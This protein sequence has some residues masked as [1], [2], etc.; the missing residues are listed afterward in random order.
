MAYSQDLVKAA[1][2][3]FD[4]A[5]QLNEERQRPRRQDVAGYLYGIAGECALKE[6]MRDSGMRPSGTHGDDPFYAHFP[7]LKTLLRDTLRGR[8]AGELRAFAEDDG[9][10]N[11]WDVAMRYAPPQDIA[12]RLVDLWR[13]QAQRLVHAME[14][15]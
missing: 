7:V 5:E 4:A 2:R 8:R 12:P 9:L 13:E 14:T 1:R 3:H 11:G 6:I 15:T 10:M